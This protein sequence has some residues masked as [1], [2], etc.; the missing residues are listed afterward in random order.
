MRV[1]LNEAYVSAVRN[2]G[3]VPLVLP[4]LAPDDLESL[5]PALAGLVLSGGG[6]VDPREYGAVPSPLSGEPH[7]ARDICE[8]ALVGIAHERRIP[9]LAI[10]RGMQVVNVALGGTL[11]QDIP[12]ECPGALRHDQ[13]DQRT[14]R[15]HE[16]R[17]E[18][19]SILARALGAT[20][21]T[22]NSSHHQ[23]IA[24][25]A[26]GLQITA[27]SSDGVIEGAEWTGDDWWM[28]AVQW[29]PE[30]LVDAVDEW[31]RALFRAF[32]ERVR[33]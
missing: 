23:A 3:L 22:V 13:G 6:D 31:D 16:I 7:R 18:P 33:R 26:D 17:A 9:T 15:V 29:H 24:R 25:P 32:A 20:H 30:E 2:A 27:R 10:C 11:V 5:V 4:P 28:L 8:L 14:T 1:R 12:T 21:L 19:R